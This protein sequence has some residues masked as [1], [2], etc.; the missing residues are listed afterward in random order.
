MTTGVGSPAHVENESGMR[1]AADFHRWLRLAPG[2]MQAVDADGRLAAV[3]DGWLTR[4]GYRGE[5]VIG[6]PACDFFTKGERERGPDVELADMFRRG[7]HDDVARQMVASDGGEIDVLLSIA[8]ADGGGPWAS[9]ASIADVTA[10]RAA[11][12]KLVASERHYRSLV[13]DQI[14]LV[15]LSSPDG[16]LLYVNDA[17]ARHYAQRPQELI[18]RSIYD[19]IPEDARAAVEAHLRKVC[20]VDASVTDQNRVIRPDGQSRWM[21]WTNRALRDEHGRVIG[22]HSVGR[23]IEPFVE[24]EQRLKESEARYR[25]LA[26]HSTDMVLELDL[27]FRRRYVSPA[28]R[29]IFGSSRRI[30]S[31]RRPRRV[32]IPRTRSASPRRCILC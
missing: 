13:E 32:R 21:S 19:F 16:V 6:R 3:S 24:A 20:A 29:D 14:D 9:T 31:A 18:G 28:C 22:I 2:M 8:P 7:R 5:D 11:E 4:L 23:D 17:Y 10:L 27:D 30:S 25:L 26:E 15:S 1:T 12:R